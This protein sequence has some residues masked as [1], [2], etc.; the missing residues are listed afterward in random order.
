MYRYC[1]VLDKYEGMIVVDVVTT[2][3]GNPLDNFL[4]R[5]VTF[6][7]DGVLDGANAITFVGTLAYITCDR[8]LV[9]VSLEDPCHPV[10]KAIID[11]TLLK[12]PRAVAAQFRYCYVADEE[13]VKVFD[14]TNPLHPRAVSELPVHDVHNI[15]LA[16]TYAYLAAGK[17]GLVIVDIEKPDSPKIDQTYDAGGCIN[18]LH[19][20]KLGITYA[21]EF[22]YLADGK[23]GM[24]IVQLTN[25]TMPTIHGYSPRPEPRL[26]ATYKIP[27]HGEA[28][29][30]SRGLDRDRAVDECG[31]QIGV[32]G[33]IGARPFNFE[34]QQKMY[35]HHGHLW[36][37]CDDPFWPGYLKVAAPPK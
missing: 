13:G 35:L 31:N 23:N 25:P 3:N 14:I 29:A 8:G 7:P 18:D 19:D 1:Y 6:N 30:I 4:H 26:I 21:S 12:H 33:R 15:Y 27:Q 10:V 11:E 9:I 34:E 17:Q 2:I 20:V 24:R 16:R 36:T 5:E 28:L 37:V 32:F 22:A